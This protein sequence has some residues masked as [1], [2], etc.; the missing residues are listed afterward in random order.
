LVSDSE[1]REKTA[2]SRE[3]SPDGR[4]SLVVAT[5]PALFCE[6]LSRQLDNEPD[7]QVVG[8]AWDKDQI[9]QVLS[10]QSPRVLLFDY[11][12][13]GPNGESVI[14]GLRRDVPATRILVLA[15]RSGDE[16][17][18]QV[19]RA[20]ASGL[21]G[22]QLEFTTLV[23]AIHAVAAGEIWAHRLATA[24][25]LEHLENFSRRGSASEGFLTK[26]E[27]EIVDGVARGLRNKEIACRLNISQKTVKSHLNNIFRKLKLDGRT[28]LALLGLDGAQP[29]T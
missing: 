13:M 27:R 17:V 25:I 12:A 24:R 4:V 10:R 21:V 5:Q 1:T 9:R 14:R 7:L 16:T 28:A 15:T 26:R 6:I 11:E 3:V 20:G 19:L 23:R 18:E 8:Q 2:A 22:K 29:K